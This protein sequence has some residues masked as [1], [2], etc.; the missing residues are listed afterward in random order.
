MNRSAM[1]ALIFDGPAADT[2]RSTI[3]EIPVPTPGTS[4]ITIDVEYA[5]VNFKDV[6]SR[7]GDPGYVDSWPYVPGLEVAGRVLALGNGVQGF[8]VGDRVLALTNAGGLAEVALAEAQLTAAVP[9]GVDLA[10]AAMVPGVLTTAELLLY[11]L[12]RV[13]TGDAIVVHSASGAVGAAIA[14]LSRLHGEIDLI[15]AV[16]AAN[17]A[18][19]AERVGYKT[20][21]VRGPGLA[22]HVRRHRDGRGVDVVLD[23][24]GTRWLEEDLRMLA[25]TGRI[26]L[27][28]NAAG[29]GL[30]PLPPTGALFGANASV[31]GFSLAALSS[32]DPQRVAAAM[33]RVLRHLAEGALTLDPTVVTGLAA[34]IEAQERLATGTGAGKYVVRVA[35]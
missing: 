29:D 16:G 22:D 31:G 10:D 5:G 13:R 21:V 12:A 18:E 4:Q 23:S 28:G 14:Q 6:M 25:P 33:S 26:I 24:Q 32:A 34:A 2:S 9:H 19:A 30:D 11:D 8:R 3:S 1:R 17:R 15:G 27:F 7:R 20:V 35:G